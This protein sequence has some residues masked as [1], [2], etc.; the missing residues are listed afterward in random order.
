MRIFEWACRPCGRHIETRD[1]VLPHCPNCGMA[2]S[3]QWSF[4]FSKPMPEHFNHAVGSYVRNRAELRSEFSRRSDE[5]SERMNFAVDLQPIDPYDLKHSPES[6][7]ATR[8]Q[9][10]VV[11][12]RLT[13][14]GKREPHLWL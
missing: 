12:R 5:M 14:E 13:D 1:R 3:R 10:D 4:A 11:E 2:M 6:F 8:D 9:T 7:G